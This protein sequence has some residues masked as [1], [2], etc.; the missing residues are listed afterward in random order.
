MENEMENDR[1]LRFKEMQEMIGGYSRTSL[2]RLQKQ[3][4]FPKKLQLGPRAVGW[5]LS[6][7]QKWIKSLQG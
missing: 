6:D 1:I 4:G 3:D 5:R 7:I 2:W